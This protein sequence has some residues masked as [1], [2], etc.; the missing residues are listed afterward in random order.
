MS[1]IHNISSKHWRRENEA[2]TEKTELTTVMQISVRLFS[3]PITQ[4][5]TQRGEPRPLRISL[6]FLSP[7]NTS[8]Q[9]WPIDTYF[10]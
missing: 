1:D 4:A 7:L 2:E 3:S 10:T 6:S 9:V 5:P 8:K